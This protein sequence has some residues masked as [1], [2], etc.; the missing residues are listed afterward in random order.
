MLLQ[1]ISRDAEAEEI[2]IYSIAKAT[3][4]DDVE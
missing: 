3:N 2:V 1:D 4:M